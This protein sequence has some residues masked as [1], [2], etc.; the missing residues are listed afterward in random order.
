MRISI[1]AATRHLIKKELQPVLP[2]A[3]APHTIVTNPYVTAVRSSLIRAA[4]TM[5]QVMAPPTTTR[6]SNPHIIAL[7]T[8]HGITRRRS[9]C[10]KKEASGV[11]ITD[12]AAENSTHCVFVADWVCRSTTP[13]FNVYT[14]NLSLSYFTSHAVIKMMMIIQVILFKVVDNW[15][16]LFTSK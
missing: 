6:N 14:R 8:S 3:M 4:V 11:R 15:N 1:R 16:K 10:N 9:Y 12:L 7:P 5:K 2:T 13:F